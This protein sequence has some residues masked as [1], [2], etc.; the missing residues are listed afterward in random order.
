MQYLRHL[1][2]NGT[3]I[4]LSNNDKNSIQNFGVQKMSVI[5]LTKFLSV[6]SI[7]AVLPIVSLAE[8]LTERLAKLES[9]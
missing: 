5:R 6:F 3:D 9:H 4:A 8:D 1:Y 2:F 7:I